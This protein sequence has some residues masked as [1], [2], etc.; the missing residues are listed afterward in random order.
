MVSAPISMPFLCAVSLGLRT[1]T[2]YLQ[3]CDH[4]QSSSYG[5]ARCYWLS[6]GC[7]GATFGTGDAGKC[8]PYIIW[9]DKQVDSTHHWSPEL[10]SG[11]FFEYFG[12]AGHVSTYASSVRCVLGFETKQCGSYP[13]LQLCDWYE[14][15]KYGAAQCNQ[16]NGG[17]QG[18]ANTHCYPYDIWSG[19]I[20]DSE[21]YHRGFYLA[22]GTLFGVS[23]D[24]SRGKCSN[25]F[26]FSVRCVLGLI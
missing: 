4:S 21:G 5:A 15:S 7:Q 16:F 25:T 19:T 12:D 8:F 17:C 22:K 11:R 26:T 20:M 2:D 3:L 24:E 23:C 9:S 1:S 13:G 10:V 18:A 6:G 14:S